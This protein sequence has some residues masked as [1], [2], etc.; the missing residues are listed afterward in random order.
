MPWPAVAACALRPPGACPSAPPLV[1]VRQVDPTIRIELRYATARNFTGA[2][3]P[4]YDAALALLRPAAAEALARAQ[5]DLG[6][7]GLG[8]LV[9][10]AYRP[11]RATRAMVDWARRHG[12]TAWVDSGYIAPR[13]R[14]N[15]GLA[16][17]VTLVR[18]ADGAELDLGT[19]FDE[20]SARAHTFAAE[21][22]VLA[23]RLR[24]RRAMQA[25]GFE[26]YDK[27]WWHFALPGDAPPLDVP[28]RC[29]A[30]RTAPPPWSPPAPT[31]TPPRR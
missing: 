27:E 5:E 31:S 24:L 6:H 1:E 22:E 4:G 18:R 10:D 29:L 26:P 13:S 30:A 8:L 3:L 21:G 14:H 16:V 17:D 11:V 23:R 7:D 19:P 2:P 28:L 25:A 9:W 20:F 12:H 15:L